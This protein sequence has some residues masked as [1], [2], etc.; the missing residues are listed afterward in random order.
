MAQIT[1][2]PEEHLVPASMPRSGPHKILG[3][4]KHEWRNQRNG[5][6]FIFPWI[7]G[8]I[9][10]T[11]IPMLL[12]LYDS[13]TS[14]NGILAPHWIGLQNYV[15][16]VTRDPLIRVSVFN[17]LYFTI[18]GVSIG[19]LL[20]LALALLLNQRVKGIGIFRTIYY[21]P[22]MLP[23]VV[24]AFI[25]GL[26]LHPQEGILNT[27]LGFIGIKG[28]GWFYSPDWSKP[29]FILLSLW[30]VG[31][32]VVIYLAG[33][34][35][36]PRHLIEAAVVDGANWLQRLRHVILPMLSPVIFFNVVLAVIASFQNFQ[37]IYFLTSG[38]DSNGTTVGLGGPAHSTYT[39]GLL[40]FNTAFA[41]GR[42]GYASALSWLMFI[43]VLVI[44]LLLFRFGSFLV[45]YEGETRRK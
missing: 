3:L 31:N 11:M 36:I 18:F 42:L 44:T 8:F 45:Y 9:A 15:N 20:S 25:F 1:T 16:I 39:W 38:G 43:V 6:L 5:L 4:S 14:Y 30:G 24:S 2:R 29:A 32:S 17:T 7:I 34:Q 28:P 10:F 22:T 12:S 33:L 13:F 41:E 27:F 23:I 21:L 37:S 26:V 40:I 19:T 35:D